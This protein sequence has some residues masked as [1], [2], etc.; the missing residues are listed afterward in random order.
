MKYICVASSNR[1]GYFMQMLVSLGNNDTNGWQ[2]LVRQEPSSSMTSDLIKLATER[3]GGI[4]QMN[5]HQ[6][7][8]EANTF[9]VCEEAMNLEADALLYLDDDMVLSPD[10]LTLC[11]WYLGLPHPP[12]YAG[13]C[14][15][16]EASDPAR[17]YTIS[18][19]DTWRGLVGQGFCYTPEQWKD[20]VRP[21][22]WEDNKAWAGHG[23]DWALSCRAQELGRIFLRPHLSRSQ[24][25][26]VVGLHGA[27]AGTHLEPF[28]EHIATDPCRE[29][30][31][32]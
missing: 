13:L 2:L 22:F 28:P 4:S 10:A 6:E 14:L 9:K 23:Y 29:F 20:F 21:N 30:R 19:K 8:A 11:N 17:P 16:N 7:G 3:F 15:C 5:A 31:I 32:E 24:H 1:M 27:A 12:E 25:I 18:D 26:G